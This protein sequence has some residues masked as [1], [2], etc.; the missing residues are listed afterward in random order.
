MTVAC[1]GPANR[2]SVKLHMD[3]VAGVVKDVQKQPLLFCVY[4]KKYDR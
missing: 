3:D 1:V 2:V 4:G